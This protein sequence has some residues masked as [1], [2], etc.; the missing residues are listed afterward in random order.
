M[1]MAKVLEGLG[2]KWQQRWNKGGITT[3]HHKI[4]MSRTKWLHNA[5]GQRRKVFQRYLPAS[6]IAAAVP[7]NPYQS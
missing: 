7:S 3:H 6:I 1:F 5:C 2:N 4:Q